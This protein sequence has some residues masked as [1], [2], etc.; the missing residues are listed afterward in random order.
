MSLVTGKV[1]AVRGQV[2]EVSFTGEK[3]SVHDVLV[4][5]NNPLVKMEVY[6]SSGP[7]S[8]YCLLLTEGSMIS[9]GNGVINTL[10]PVTIPVGPEVLG[11]VLDLFGNPRDKGGQ[12][13]T[14]D[15]WPIYRD[16]PLYNDITT[17]KEILFTGIKGID[18]FCPIL[19]RGKIRLFGGAR[20]E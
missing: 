5:E 2:V 15:T 1:I 16:A 12:I 19:Q 3:P 7:D 13:Q 17:P 11:R 10:K 8:Y 20:V 14:K 18:L 9:R 4:L 6:T